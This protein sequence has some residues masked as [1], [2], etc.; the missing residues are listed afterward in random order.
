[1]PTISNESAFNT[2][3]QFNTEIQYG[4]SGNAD[5]KQE[6]IGL[7]PPGTALAT[8]GW[9]IKKLLYDAT[10]RLIKIRWAENAESVG[11]NEFIHAFVN[12]ENLDYS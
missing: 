10:G 4:T 7:A 1:M 5:G 3:S 12:P 11:T 6:Y 9:Q 8:D 2:E